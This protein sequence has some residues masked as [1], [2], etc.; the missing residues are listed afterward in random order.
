[1]PNI[2]VFIAGCPLCDEAV[3]TVN[4]TACSK[5]TVTVYDLREGCETMECRERA[6]KYGVTRVP[7]VV[8]DGQIAGCCK[9][10]SKVDIAILRA[11]G[12]G[13]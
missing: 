2:E 11:M 3:R 6:Q 13:G 10:S 9:G 7:T 12:V 8:V 5:C 4:E 1:M